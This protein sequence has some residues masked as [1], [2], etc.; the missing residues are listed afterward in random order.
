MKN[1]E[2]LQITC[3]LSRSKRVT[4]FKGTLMQT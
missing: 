2:K 4:Y 1:I 3:F